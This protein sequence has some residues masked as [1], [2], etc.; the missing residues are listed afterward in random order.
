M[1]TI[2][3][4]YK[5][6]GQA[7]IVTQSEKAILLTLEFSTNGNPD[8]EKRVWIPKSCCILNPDSTLYVKTWFVARN[9]LFSYA[10]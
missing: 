6:F 10:V 8:N 4:G 9:R 1:V 3:T 2:P 5:N 7:A